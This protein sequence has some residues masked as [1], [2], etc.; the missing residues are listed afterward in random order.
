MI[1][2]PA[3]IA[4]RRVDG[5]KEAHDLYSMQEA[6]LPGD[7]PADVSRGFW[8]IA[9]DDDEPIGFGGLYRSVNWDDAVYLVRSGVMPSHR[10][11]GLQKRLIRVRV[12]FARRAH[13]KQAVTETNL[14]PPSAN[15]LI[16][17]GFKIFTP[18]K[19]WGFKT[20]IYFRKTF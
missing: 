3:P 4:I 15:S 14:N 10:G 5:S 13:F 6:C 18:P 7:R 17:C 2:P 16:K 11:L 1:Q 8:W 20:A 9:Y 12:A 19:P